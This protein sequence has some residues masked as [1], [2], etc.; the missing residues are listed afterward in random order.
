MVD[1]VLGREEIRLA[2]RAEEE[3]FMAIEAPLM[4]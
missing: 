4:V 1:E 2:E 3:E